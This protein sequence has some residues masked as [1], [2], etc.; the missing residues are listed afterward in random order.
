MGKE[1]D[2]W[3]EFRDEIAIP[4]LDKMFGHICM[5]CGVG[6]KLDV[7]HI[8]EKGGHP[9]LKYELDNLRYLCRF[10]CHANKTAK[11]ECPHEQDK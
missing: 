1:A 3:T 9:K 5:C 4:Y 7:D 10:P 2:R 11:K 8:I 6:G